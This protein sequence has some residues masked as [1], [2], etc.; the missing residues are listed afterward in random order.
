M[1]AATLTW[2]RHGEPVYRYIGYFFAAAYI[3]AQALEI[4]HRHGW[5]R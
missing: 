3:A 1:R 4:M 2:E 5:I